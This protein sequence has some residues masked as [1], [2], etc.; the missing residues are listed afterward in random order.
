[1]IDALLQPALA[2]EE[3]ARPLRLLAAMR[4][5]CLDGGK[6]LRPFLV[7]ETARLFGAAGDGVLRASAAVEMLHCYSLAHDDLPAMDNDDFR[8]GR[9]SLHKAFDE[10]T[11]ILTGDALQTLAFDTLADE[12]T[13]PLPQVRA[14]LVLGLARASG[15]GGMAGGQALDLEAEQSA[16]RLTEPQISLLQSM[17]TGALLRFSVEAGAVIGGADTTARS[18]LRRYGSA[19]GAAFQIADDIL[20]VEGDDKAMG[21]RSGKDA[22]RNKATLVSA[23]GIE[24]ARRR[25]EDHVS[26]AVAALRDAR[27][28]EDTGMLTQAAEF[29]RWRKF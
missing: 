22:Q 13:H 12:A 6:R 25:C 14:E 10:A 9:P 28:D 8:R 16:A 26:A 7:I 19:L 18:A 5:A 29:A 2:P 27:L 4:Y 1:M 3:L 15:L 11:A 24:A 17:K 21:K 20:D 23:M